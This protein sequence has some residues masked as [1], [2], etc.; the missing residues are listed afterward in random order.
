MQSWPATSSGAAGVPCKVGWR[1]IGC[2]ASPSFRVMMAMMPRAILVATALSYFATVGEAAAQSSEMT[3]NGAQLLKACA[4]ADHS[5]I[6]FC[7]GYI[8]AAFDA[9][10]GKSICAP[11]GVT[12]NQLFDIIIPA[13][14]NAPDLL[15][16]NATS[17]I[18]A[19]LRKTYPCN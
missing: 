17:A 15:K 19:I 10:D 9:I 6:G 1:G 8:Q 13:L 3:L 7:N 12:R 11:K 18:G 2:G 4:I 14:E 5:W 16:L